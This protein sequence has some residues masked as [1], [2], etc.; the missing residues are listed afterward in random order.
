M[1]ETNS[2]LLILLTRV[3]KQNP[4]IVVSK[5]WKADLLIPLRIIPAA[6]VSS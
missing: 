2:T 1:M 5:I 4:S 3:G 6:P